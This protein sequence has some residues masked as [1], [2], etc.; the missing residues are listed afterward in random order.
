M[1]FAWLSS[2]LRWA[3][4][5]ILPH[6]QQQRPQQLIARG[7]SK[8]MSKSAKKRMPL[9]TKRARK[10][11]YKG[12]GGT[13]EG[14]HTSKGKYM[15]NKLKRLELVIPDLTGFKVC[16]GE[17]SL[18]YYTRHSDEVALTHRLIIISRSSNLISQP[19]QVVSHPKND[20]VLLGSVEHPRDCHHTVVD[21]QTNSFPFSDN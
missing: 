10:G 3:S 2:P 4:E 19:P 12:K 16:A 15:I 9:T 8:Y 20:L 21:K 13:T 17:Y 14:R 5:R 7:F 6:L 1:N 18:Y 11:F